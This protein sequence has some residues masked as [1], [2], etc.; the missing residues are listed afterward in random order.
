MNSN[1]KHIGIVIVDG[2]GF[3]NF[4]LS[5]VLI[6]LNAQ[7]KQVTIF[8]G[9]PKDVYT[10]FL[11]DG[12]SVI[13]LP[14]YSE[15]GKAWFFR[16]LKEL[17]HLQS[18]KKNNAGIRYNLLKNKN[19]SNTKR[20]CLTRLAFAITSVFNSERWINR[21][22]AVQEK[23]FKKHNIY[24]V[25]NEYLKQT[26]VDLLFFTHQRPPYIALLDSAA[27]ELKIK[28]TAFIFSWDNLPSKGRM[29]A[30]F[31]CYLVWSDLMKK[32]LLQFYPNVKDSNI[33][34]VGTPQF[35]PYVLERYE[36]SK[37]DFINKFNLNPNLKTICYSCGDVSTSF[38]DPLYIN[39][40][41]NAIKSKKIPEINFIVRTSP[42]E[43]GSR[44]KEIQNIYPNIKWNF[45]NWRLSREQHPEIW[46]QRMPSVNDIKN[47]RALVSYVDLNIN[48]CS[49]MS[50]DCMIFG[51]PVINVAFGS[52]TNKLY[53]DQKYLKYSCV[54]SF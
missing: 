30:N 18:H 10:E 27:K 11:Q 44:F 45:P 8:S 20:G 3:K 6:Q 52:T 1:T 36:V 15:T 25:Y 21:F 47:L 5:D 29:A 16:K 51:K 2:V 49:T 38:N 54:Y 31:D 34:V 12:I 41:A 19:M 28:T 35:E 26:N 42:A 23:T 4:V 7:F 33:A 9:L 50:L 32:E 14:I 13:E 24:K 46:S 43:D 37:E 40:I 17:A 53:H 22:Y 39:S 48:M